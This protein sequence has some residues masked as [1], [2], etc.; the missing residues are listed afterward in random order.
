VQH[1]VDLLSGVQTRQQLGA[2][3]VADTH[4]AAAAASV[5][6]ANP[7]APGPRGQWPAPQGSAPGSPQVGGGVLQRRTALE[8]ALPEHASPTTP[9]YA[10]SSHPHSFAGSEA[11][12]SISSSQPVCAPHHSS[13]CLCSTDEFNSKLSWI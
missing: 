1:L 10:A 3:A 7:P 5:G 4:G 12:F 6:G 13:V 2:A 11:A 8:S 9:R